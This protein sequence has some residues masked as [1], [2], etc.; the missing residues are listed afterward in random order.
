M[1]QRYPADKPGRSAG[2]QVTGKSTCRC[3]QPRSASWVFR[4]E[5]C[6]TAE[7]E[8][9]ENHALASF[10]GL[11]KSAASAAGNCPEGRGPVRPIEFALGEN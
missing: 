8:A 10:H 1:Q 7:Q 2:A 5:K 3:A 6:Q 9:K 11:M 4:V